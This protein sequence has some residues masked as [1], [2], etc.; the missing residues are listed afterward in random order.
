MAVYIRFWAKKMLPLE[1]ANAVIN[2]IVHRT[3][4]WPTEKPSAMVTIDDR[5]LTF[6]GTWPKIEALKA[7]KPWNK[8]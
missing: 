8:K 3:E 7:F 1:D 4:S 5:A 2:N 6:D